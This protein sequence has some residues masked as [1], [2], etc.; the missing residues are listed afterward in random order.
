MT[1]WLLADLL[2]ILH[3]K[4]Y[5]ASTY[6][7]FLGFLLLLVDNIWWLL[8]VLQCQV[9]GDKVTALRQVLDDSER[10]VTSLC[11][12]FLN[13]SKKHGQTNSAD[14]ILFVSDQLKKK[15]CCRFIRLD[16]QVSPFSVLILSAFN[17]NV[18]CC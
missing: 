15:A 7:F 6:F 2:S 11:K 18:F 13:S 4:I 8:L 9:A 10:K 14:T 12:S 3:H 16:M 1:L 17:T 5:F